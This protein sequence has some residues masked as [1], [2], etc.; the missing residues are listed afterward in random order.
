MITISQ[1]PASLIPVYNPTPFVI[2]SDNNNETGFFYIADLYIGQQSGSLTLNSR[3]RF[4]ARPD[5]GTAVIDLN[6]IVESYISHHF[7]D[8][9]VIEYCYNNFKIFQIKFG[10]EYGGVVYPNLTTSNEITAFNGALPYV[11][12]LSFSFTDYELTGA[13]KKFLTNCPAINIRTGQKFYLY[14]K[15]N[16]SAWRVKYRRYSGGVAAAN[17]TITNPGNGIVQDSLFYSVQCGS[18]YLATALPGAVDYYSVQIETTLGAV[19]S[20]EKIITIDSDCTKFDVYRLHFLNSLGGFDAFNFTKLSEVSTD[21][22]R[23]HYK[24]RK[25]NINSVGTAFTYSISDREDTTSFTSYKDKVTVNSNWI[26]EA[27]SIWLKELLI[28]PVVFWES[29]DGFIPVKI[30]DNIYKQ[31]KVVNRKM[32]NLKVSFEIAH[33]NYAQRY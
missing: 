26:S 2:S 10:E 25:G 8:D 20:E 17:V 11:D 23:S 7:K 15:T 3:H 18:S 13:G 22:Q 24:S 30:T 33:T 12:Y 16:S 28:S 9:S 27:E 5:F 4:P 32:F 21:I 31:E 14:F 29:P 6:R 19:L 1:Q